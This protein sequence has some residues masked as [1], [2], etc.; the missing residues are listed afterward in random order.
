[1]Q[2]PLPEA[3]RTAL[4]QRPNCSLS[5]MVDGQSLLCCTLAPVPQMQSF[6]FP[7]VR[8]PCG[9]GAQVMVEGREE[10]SDGGE[11]NK[12]HKHNPK[13]TTKSPQAESPHHAVF[14][15]CWVKQVRRKRVSRNGPEFTNEKHIGRSSKGSHFTTTSDQRPHPSAAKSWSRCRSGASQC[16]NVDCPCDHWHLSTALSIA[17]TKRVSSLFRDTGL[18]RCAVYFLLMLMSGTSYGRV[19]CDVS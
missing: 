18:W 8:T 4:L 12:D 1:M 5:C 14:P 19:N 10:Q 16:S 6:F 3:F 15:L 17:W 9:H 13:Q 11:K 2:Q 7:R